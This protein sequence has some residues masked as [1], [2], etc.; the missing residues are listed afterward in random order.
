MLSTRRRWFRGCLLVGL[1]LLTGE[2]AWRH[3]HD[4]VFADR[5]AEIV[6]GKIYRGAWQKRWPMK[7]I[8]R[9][10]HIK[11]VLA[12]AHPTDHPLSVKERALGT[13]LGF[14]WVHVPIVDDRGG[15][16]IHVISRKLDEAAAVLA[17]SENY[18]IYFHCHHGINRASMVQIAYR[19][20]FCG[21]T[22]EQATAEIE[23]MF[24]LVRATHGPDY[25]H[26]R[27]YYDEIVLPYRAS[28]AAAVANAHAVAD[29]QS[30]VK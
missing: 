23:R 29:H 24:G 7:R 4:F 30:V 15:S 20:K 5:F 6:P 2:Q 21:W 12:L 17:N 22:L 26:M 14:H 18:P 3:G 10:Y 25:R 9:Q 8:V 28:S 11:T 27:L 1:G 13:E 16:D 19:T